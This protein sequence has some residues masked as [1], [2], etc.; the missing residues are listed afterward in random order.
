MARLGISR[1]DF[2][3]GMSLKS[4]KLLL[5]DIRFWIVFLFG[6]RLFG[7]TD[8]PLE[9]GHN[10]RQ[11]FTNMIT[12]NFVNNG[13]DLLHPQIDMAGEKSGIVGSEF[14]IFNFL[15]YLFSSIFEFEHWHG[16]LINLVFT[17][18]GLYFFY[19]L[20]K[21][22]FQEKTAFSAT[23]ILSVS[24]WFG[25]GRKI[26]PDTFSVSLVI[27]GFWFAY[28][29]LKEGKLYQVLLFLCF[30]ALGLLSKIP[31][32]YLF[33]L[34]VFIPFQK[35]ILLRRRISI[36]IF[37]IISAGI[38][39]LW[40]FYW[41]PLLL[42]E[43]QFQ[44]F[45]E[46]SFIEGIQEILPLIPMALKRF[47]YYAFYGFLG[48][49]ASLIGLYFFFK[50]SKQKVIISIG[51]TILLFIAF[52]LKTGAVFP[53]HNYYVIPFVPIMA[54]FA[55]IA[56]SKLP[57]RLFPIALLLIGIESIANQQHGFFIS[58][59][60]KYKLD[61]ESICDEY[62]PKQE[63]IIINGGQSHQP[64]YFANRKGWTI[65]NYQLIDSERMDSL[66]HL[67]ASKLIIDKHLLDAQEVSY[68]IIFENEHFQ[69]RDLKE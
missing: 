4:I 3:V 51:V 23:I 18:L 41:V 46:K 31:A 48:F 26:M 27:I 28:S 5:A 37:S 34:F 14:P 54:I 42:E 58:E 17:S 29:Y 25:Y 12:R 67:G 61:L 47:Y 8:A 13:L 15:S 45:I 1:K 50:N 60:K 2:Q 62:I 35:D 10:W 57:N 38:A 53:H 30:T 11:A 16:R 7:I 21:T 19:K 33:G 52:I 64:I 24:I 6:I 69:I 68:P 56:I 43:H 9:T 66:I 36:I 20:V 44:L 65:H 59:S 49:A 55:G 39:Y 22:F 40:Y 63:L 32:L